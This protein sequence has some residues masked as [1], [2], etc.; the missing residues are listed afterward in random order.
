MF[1]FKNPIDVASVLDLIEVIASAI[2]LIATPLAVLAIIITGFRF[3]SAAASGKPDALAKT[4]S[5]FL[6]VIVGT[7]AIV[8][9]TF[10]AEMAVNTVKMIQ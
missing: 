9:A 2:R 8:G 7:A 1:E 6:W 3:V 5:A 4:K 10:L